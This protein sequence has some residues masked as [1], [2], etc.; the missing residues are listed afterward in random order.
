MVGGRLRVEL[1]RLP[2]LMAELNN[3]SSSQA[4]GARGIPFINVLKKTD[5]RLRVGS[6]Q[7]SDPSLD[8]G[9]QRRAAGRNAGDRQGPPSLP[10]GHQP[11]PPKHPDSRP[12]GTEDKGSSPLSAFLFPGLCSQAL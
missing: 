9:D 8:V 10:N 6:G 1:G 5:R 12:P 11:R 2:L 4:Y 3:K 7:G